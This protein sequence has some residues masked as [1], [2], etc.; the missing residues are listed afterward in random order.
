MFATQDNYKIKI[1]LKTSF[2]IFMQPKHPKRG[3]RRMT[4]EMTFTAN[5]PQLAQVS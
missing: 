5:S 1:D 3:Q 4:S 2:T